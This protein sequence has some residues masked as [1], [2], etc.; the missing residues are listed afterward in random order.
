M[1]LAVVPATACPLLV[2]SVA[3]AQNAECA[4]VTTLEGAREACNVAVDLARGSFLMA[5][6]AISGGNPMPGSGAASGRLGSVSV[7]LRTNLVGLSVPDPSNVGSGGGPVPQDDEIV[8]PAPRIEGH[9]GIFRGL[10]DSLL[11]ID[12]GD[13][14]AAD[15]GITSTNFRLTAG[16]TFSAFA[17]AGYDAGLAGFRTISLDLSQS[18]MLYF[19]NTGLDLGLV[20]LVGEVGHPSGKNQNPE[21]EFAGVDDTE[22]TTFYG[23]GLRVGI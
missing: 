12:Q 7:T 8:A 6:L 4:G 18:R 16:T 14:V 2:A 1:P 23:V 17:V 15:G 21:T 22:G 20:T 5:G 19:L 10:P 11:A 13:D 3:A 9:A